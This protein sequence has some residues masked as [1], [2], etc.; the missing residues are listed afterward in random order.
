MRRW[1]TSGAEQI[2][3]GIRFQRYRPNG[4]WKVV[5]HDH[6]NSLKAF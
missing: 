4:V 2:P 6:G 1:K 3:K 5:V